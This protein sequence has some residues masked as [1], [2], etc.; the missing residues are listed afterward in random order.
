MLKQ[1]YAEAKLIEG[2]TGFRAE[3][4]LVFSDAY[5]IPAVSRRDG[6]VIL[7]AR[8]LGEHLRRRGGTIPAVRVREVYDRL[9]AALSG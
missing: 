2:I 3:P 5:L 1:A 8:M 7:P 4:L 9:A 6:V